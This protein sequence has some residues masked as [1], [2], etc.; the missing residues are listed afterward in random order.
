MGTWN[1]CALM[2]DLPPAEEGVRSEPDCIGL[3]KQETAT[4]AN[5]NFLGL[6]KSF[7]YKI[8]NL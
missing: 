5:N 2:S 7:H 8:S 6:I 3:S 1:L 4:S